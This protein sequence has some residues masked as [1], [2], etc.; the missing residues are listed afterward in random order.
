MFNDYKRWYKGRKIQSKQF[1]SFQLLFREHFKSMLRLQQSTRIALIKRLFNVNHSCSLVNVQLF[2][3]L[4]SHCIVASLFRLKSATFLKHTKQNLHTNDAN[5]TL[6]DKR[7][8][9]KT[10][11]QKISKLKHFKQ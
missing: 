2:P 5:L 6:R 10:K 8:K 1:A 11:W 4:S 9:T 3:G 7:E